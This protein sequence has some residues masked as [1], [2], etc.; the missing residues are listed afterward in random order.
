MANVSVLNRRDL[1]QHALTLKICS[2]CARGDPSWLP[3]LPACF[4]G[5]KSQSSKSLSTMTNKQ[6]KKYTKMSKRGGIGI[7]PA[8]CSP[9]WFVATLHAEL[10]PPVTVSVLLPVLWTCCRL[11]KKQNSALTWMVTCKLTA[12]ICDCT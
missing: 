6:K 5:Q 12:I 4:E 2:P 3:L 11:G 9:Q 1:P 8:A 10:A 7:A